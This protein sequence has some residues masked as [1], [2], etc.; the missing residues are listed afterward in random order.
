MAN[1]DDGYISVENAA[2]L[3][4]LTPRHL[5]RLVQDGWIKK[6]A[7]GHYS[8]VGVVQGRIRQLEHKLKEGS[9]S[10]AQNTA[11]LARAKEIEIKIAERQRKLIKVT[12]AT[13]VIDAIAARV[14]IA[15]EGLPA[16]FTRDLDLRQ[17]A[18]AVVDATLRSLAQSFATATLALEK[19]GDVL[20][21]VA[22]GDTGSVG[23]EE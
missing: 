17:Q 5:S 1:Q 23:E 21:S 14:R 15:F 18:E 3:V 4:L 2:K 8:L 16:Q 20:E 11:S 9:K 22:E 12:E 13:E 6:T 7:G 10:A 19:G